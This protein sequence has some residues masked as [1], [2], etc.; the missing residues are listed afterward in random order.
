MKDMDDRMD[1]QVQE[2][3]EKKKESEVCEGEKTAK[4]NKLAELQKEKGDAEGQFKTESEEWNKE[5]TSLKEQ[6]AT[7]SKICDYVPKTNT[8]A[9]KLCDLK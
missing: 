1:K 4:N 3:E 7:R 6:L 5:I 8:A 2:I 9:E